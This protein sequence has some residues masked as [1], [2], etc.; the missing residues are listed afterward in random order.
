MNGYLTIEDVAR[1]FPSEH[2]NATHALTICRWI[3]NGVKGIKLR[4]YKP[5]KRYYIK[6]EWVDE[7]LE[8]ADDARQ[9]KAA[10]EQ[11]R[12]RN[13]NRKSAAK[14][15]LARHEMKVAK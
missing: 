13:P 11:G 9:G 1:L 5:G 15:G 7:F 2:G 10:S 4:A 14:R 12:R 6:P 3:K 8:A